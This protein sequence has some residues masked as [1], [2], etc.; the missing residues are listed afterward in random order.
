M[1]KAF[2]MFL[3]QNF[4]FY[5]LERRCRYQQQKSAAAKGL[6]LPIKKKNGA[7]VANHNKKRKILR[8]SACGSLPDTA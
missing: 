5:R 4:L 1:Y 6:T 3:L 2:C 7:F 8:E